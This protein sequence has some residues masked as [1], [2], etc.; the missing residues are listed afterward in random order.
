MFVKR[1]MP[2]FDADDQAGGGQVEEQTP[3]QP[4][5]D[6]SK[7]IELTQE[8]LDSIITKRVSRTESKYADYG[9]LKEKLSVYEKA[10]QE[11]A[12][13][14]LTEL[15]RIKK[16]LEAKSEVEQSLTQQI[17]DLKKA[18]EQNKITNEFI[19][20]ATAH[21][22]AYVDDALRLADLSEVKVEEGKV[23]G[24]EGVVREIVDNKPYLI[25]STQNSKPIGQPTNGG[26]ESGGEI[27]TLESQLTTAKKEKN[28]S[29]VVEISNKLKSLLN[30]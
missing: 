8:E 16:E 12:D 25:K 5:D 21:G 17:E 11:R 29:K 15:D 19:K 23:H 3:T 6:Q 30:N 9:E 2:L 24:I 13:A 20:I 1:F 4:S 18:D 28:F 10:E 26:G 27:K 7:K 22:I 14:E